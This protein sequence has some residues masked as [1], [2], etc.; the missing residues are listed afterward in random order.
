MT[1]D[2]I[3]AF[4]VIDTQYGEKIV[5]KSPYDAKDFIKIMP[6]K[7]LQEEVAEN[8]SLREKEV[9]RGMSADNVAID[10]IED[11]IEQEGFS[12]TFAT[13]RSWESDALGRS[14]G[15]WTIDVGA[16]DEAQ[17][18]FEFCGFKTQNQTNL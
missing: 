15:A 13:H 18:Y 1:K 7:Q 5:L 11:Y 12:S 10:A 16:W 8:G 4:E 2:S 17:D 3:V 6:F 9:S 14:E